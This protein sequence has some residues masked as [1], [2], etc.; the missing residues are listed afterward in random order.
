MSIRT[1]TLIYLILLALFDT[2]IPLPLT[3]LGL[4]YVMF[5]KPDWFRRW[6][7][8]LYDHRA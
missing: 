3:A 5:E 4:I 6:V 2:V 8:Q 1:K 7:D